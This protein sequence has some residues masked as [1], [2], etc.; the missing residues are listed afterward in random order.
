MS[1]QWIFCVVSVSTAGVLLFFYITCLPEKHPCSHRGCQWSLVCAHVPI[2]LCSSTPPNLSGGARAARTQTW[3]S[4]WTALSPVSASILTTT[5][6]LRCAVVF[7]FPEVRNNLTNGFLLFLQVCLASSSPSNFHFVLVN[8]LHRIITN[9]SPRGSSWAI[10][11]FLWGRCISHPA[12]LF[13]VPPGL[14]AK[15]RHTV[16]LLWRASLYVLRHAQPG[17]PR[18]RHTCSIAS[19]N[20]E[21]TQ[22]HE[23]KQIKT[24]AIYR[25]FQSLGSCASTYDT[26]DSGLPC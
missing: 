6:T 1:Q 5:S 13:S 9:V 10:H 4:W 25:I 14:V 22:E 21:R 17:D 19:Y 20:S 24:F 11:Q 16:L 3:S 15:D 12:A 2:R 7:L 18:R 26:I 23:H 8:S